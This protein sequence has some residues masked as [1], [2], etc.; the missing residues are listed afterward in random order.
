MSKRRIEALDRHISRL[1]SMARADC[2]SSTY[3][4]SAIRD[5]RIARQEVK[6]NMEKAE[7]AKNP[8]NPTGSRNATD[9]WHWDDDY[10]GMYGF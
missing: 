1:T 4:E 2:W 5:L 9:W 7:A 6:E 3:I 10:D 8:P